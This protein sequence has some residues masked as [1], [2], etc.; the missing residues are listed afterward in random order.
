MRGNWLE[1]WFILGWDLIGLVGLCLIVVE[2]GVVMGVFVILGDLRIG[3][4][5]VVGVGLVWER[6]EVDLVLEEFCF[7]LIDGV[8]G[9]W[10]GGFGLNIELE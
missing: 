1:G 8:G 7:L 3:G 10:G 2:R 6:L 5:L 4:L 9:K